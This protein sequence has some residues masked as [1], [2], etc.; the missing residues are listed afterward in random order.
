MGLFMTLSID[1]QHNSI[2]CHFAQCCDHLNV[3]LSVIILNVVRLNVVML[4][5]VAP[6][7][8]PDHRGGYGKLS[9]LLNA[10]TSDKRSSLFSQNTNDE[11]KNVFLNLALGF[12]CLPTNPKHQVHLS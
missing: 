7:S 1:I 6:L 9:T 8:Q 11:E 5:V 10:I 2:E 4:S 3:M 12:M